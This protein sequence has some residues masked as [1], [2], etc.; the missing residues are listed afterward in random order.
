MAGQDFGKRNVG[1]RQRDAGMANP[2]VLSGHSRP[3]VVPNAPM[4][5]TEMME[6]IAGAVN[7]SH[8]DARQTPVAGI[9]P[10]SRRVT[11]GNTFQPAPFPRPPSIYRTAQDQD[12]DGDS[13]MEDAKVVNR[14]TL[15][16]GPGTLGPYS[17][18]RR[19]SF[20]SED[21]DSPVGGRFAF[22]ERRRLGL[23]PPRKRSS[24]SSSRLPVPA[25][26]DTPSPLE[27]R[28]TRSHAALL[29][30]AA[31]TGNVT[32]GP[33]RS[34]R[35]SARDSVDGLPETSNS[36]E[37]LALPPPGLQTPQAQQHPASSRD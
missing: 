11:A 20:D 15:P 1:R 30:Q 2:F 31:D 36:L 33:R 29:A 35:L 7:Q 22:M 25:P 13:L 24:I 37:H 9:F 19:S 26:A 17:K 5:T 21:D 18:K 14:Q 6:T 10:L 4:E 23:A 8:D 27:S 3:G 32:A 16:V 34:L 12:E 28:K